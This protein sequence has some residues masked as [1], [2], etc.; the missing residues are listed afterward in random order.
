MCGLVTFM[1]D[2]ARRLMSKVVF[3]LSDNQTGLVTT[4][5]FRCGR[6]NG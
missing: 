1:V 2:T 5:L 6:G 4:G 3:N